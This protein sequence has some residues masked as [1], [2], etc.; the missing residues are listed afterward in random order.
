MPQVF[1]RLRFA[2]ASASAVL[3]FLE[4]VELILFLVI[5]VLGFAVVARTRLRA[6]RAQ[7]TVRTNS[8]RS[9]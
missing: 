9:I 6:E 3:A 8:N 5:F 2:R 7:N 4:Y 1:W